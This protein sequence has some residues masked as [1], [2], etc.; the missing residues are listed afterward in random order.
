MNQEG[1][2]LISCISTQYVISFVR[3]VPVFE[4]A[5]L[6]WETIICPSAAFAKGQVGNSRGQSIIYY[7]KFP[8]ESEVL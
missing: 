7:L 5:Q 8:L 6:H 3:P 1:K 4:P 2:V